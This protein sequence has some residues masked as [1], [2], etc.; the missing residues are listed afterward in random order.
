MAVRTKR[1]RREQINSIIICMVFQFNNFFKFISQIL[2]S[3]NGAVLRREEE[4]MEWIHWCHFI[5]P[6][7]I[8]SLF[9]CGWKDKIFGPLSFLKLTREFWNKKYFEENLLRKIF[10]FWSQPKIFRKSIYWWLKILKKKIILFI[11]LRSF[12]SPAN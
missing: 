7:V 12:L 6:Q 8:Y 3:S 9:I 1:K 11:H 10:R 2:L 5:L 4:D